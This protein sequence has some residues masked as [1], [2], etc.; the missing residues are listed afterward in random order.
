MYS[1]I[2]LIMLFLFFK[3]TIGQDSDAGVDLPPDGRLVHSTNEA[4]DV[5]DFNSIYKPTCKVVIDGQM[6]VV[7]GEC[8]DKI[9]SVAQKKIVD[10]L[11][12][13]KVNLKYYNSKYDRVEPD[14]EILKSISRSYGL[15]EYTSYYQMMVESRGRASI[16]KNRAGAKGY[17]QFLDAAAK[18]F[19][20]LTKEK[21]YRINP[22]A[23]VDASSRYLVWIGQ[24]LYGQD[25]DMQDLDV[26]EHALAAYNAGHRRVAV[27]GKVRIPRFYETIRYTQSIIDLLEGYATLIMPNET[28]QAISDR[29]GFSV[30]VLKQSN[31]NVMSDSDLKAFEVLQLPKDGVSKVIIRKGMSLS[32]IQTGTGVGV[33]KLM[34][35]NNL[36]SDVIHPNDVLMIPTSLYA[37]M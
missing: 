12:I 30:D 16:K 31:F 35:F 10:P 17:M 6:K 13:K 7:A 1:I 14:L 33:S 9:A 3:N 8:V 25:V 22:Y 11:V 28:L 4:L 5:V 32:L 27:N 15:P 36:S 23:S 20:L 26:L 29:T 19:G 21:D 2:I 18:D 24:L 37:V 34:S